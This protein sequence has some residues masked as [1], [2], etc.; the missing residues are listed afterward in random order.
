M[1]KHI[2][3]V[4]TWYFEKRYSFFDFTIIA[5]LSEMLEKILEHFILK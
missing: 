1:K 4:K 5:I 2:D 3:N